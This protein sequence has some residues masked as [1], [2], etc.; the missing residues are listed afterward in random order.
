MAGRDVKSAVA[1]HCT[2]LWYYI[3][4]FLSYA[5]VA[6][7]IYA[8]PFL[9]YWYEVDVD[10]ITIVYWLSVGSIILTNIMICI[11]ML[12]AFY[13]RKY[14]I[15]YRAKALS[16][17]RIETVKSRMDARLERSPSAIKM[18]T[19]R[20]T[21]RGTPRNIKMGRSASFGTN[22]EINSEIVVEITNIYPAH[23][24]CVIAAYL[25]NEVDNLIGPVRKMVNMTRPAGT[26]LT[27]LIAH[28]G[29]SQ[30]HLRPL[31]Q[32]IN[33]VRDEH[34]P[35]PGLVLTQLHVYTSHSKAE[36]VNA[37]VDFFKELDPPVEI[38]GVFDA[39]H[40]PQPENLLRALRAML[41]T[42]ADIVQGRNCI[43]KGSRFLAI[44]FDIMYCIYHPGGAMLRGFSVF[45]GSNGYWRT[46][47]LDEVRMRNDMLTEDI[48]STMRALRKQYRVVYDRDI[49]SS[50]EAPHTFLDL[51]KQRLRWT[52]GWTEVTVKHAIPLIF[53]RG[54]GCCSCQTNN[55]GNDEEEKVEISDMN[56]EVSDGMN[57][58]VSDGKKNRLNGMETSDEN[59]DEGNSRGCCFFDHRHSKG[60]NLSYLTRSLRRRVGIFFLLVWRELYYYLA[61]QAMP[62]G[63]VALIKCEEGDCVQDVLIAMGVILF[64]FPLINSFAVYHITGSYRH[65][66]LRVRDYVIFTLLSPIYELFKFHLAV[67]GHARN[68]LRLNKWRVTR[69]MKGKAVD[70]QRE[71]TGAPSHRGE[72]SLA[73]PALREPFSQDSNDDVNV[74]T[75]SDSAVQVVDNKSVVDNKL[76]VDNK[77]TD[78]Q[79]ME[80]VLNL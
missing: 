38:I 33:T 63:A 40:Y 16:E 52:Q 80:I 41:M 74:S 32:L 23:V 45:G 48:D 59:N 1:K 39:D 2:V 66:G 10:D 72:I 51:V 24:G 12:L 22:G 47:T 28:N 26:K 50:E 44:E 75:S 76:T 37:A 55:N 11:E 61:A 18:E 78:N 9:V 27:V 70:P 73:I 14:R 67:Y 19:P 42:D 58:E 65:P 20:K 53:G 7:T 5:Y 43:D 64:L 30:E 4:V 35:D 46:E 29:G 8:I 79:S 68:M 17:K 69:R 21:V 56:K 31:S 77:V 71:I 57:K 3:R 13:I 36:N 15:P 49:I 34:G 25:P 62:A 54:F 60:F 6:A